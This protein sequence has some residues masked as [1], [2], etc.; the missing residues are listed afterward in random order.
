[1]GRVRRMKKTVGKKMEKKKRTRRKVKKLGRIKL[2]RLLLQA[3]S[4]L[5]KLQKRDELGH[6]FASFNFLLFFSLVLSWVLLHS[7]I[8][9]FTFSKKKKKKKKKVLCVDATL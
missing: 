7:L 5:W 9:F 3:R 6:A 8:T 1:M 4:E 2:M